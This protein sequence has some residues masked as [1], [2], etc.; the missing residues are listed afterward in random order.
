MKTSDFKPLGSNS[1]YISEMDNNLEHNDWK[2][3]APNLSRLPKVNPF[4]VPEQYFD[5]LSERICASVFV[6][7]LMAKTGVLEGD[8]PEGY[9]A[10]LQEEITAKITLESLNLPKQEGF[11]VPEGYFSK[12]NESILNK[13]TQ[14][15]AS[16]PK[17]RKLWPNRMTQYAAA[18]CLVLISG[19]AV[20][21]NQD[22]LFH[23]TPQNNTTVSVT[24]DPMLWDIDEQTIM[25]QMETG[26]SGFISNTSATSAELESYILDNYSQYEIAS[27]L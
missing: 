7:D 13:V 18:A 14:G 5:D 11:A 15:E 8:V 17:A 12:I 22:N 4:A 25:D 21:L 26:S 1:I 19:I 24:E 3:E 6:D 20:Y 23:T 27:N 2:D 10:Q 16:T 9:F